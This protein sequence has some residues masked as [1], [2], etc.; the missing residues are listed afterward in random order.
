[1]PLGVSLSVPKN[2]PCP[3]F[4]IA[5]P[6][7]PGETLAAVRSLIHNRTGI[8]D[9]ADIF[10]VV[11]EIYAQL[12]P[13]FSLIF[14]WAQVIKEN[15]AQEHLFPEKLN[16]RCGR[17]CDGVRPEL[18][19]FLKTRE[20]LTVYTHFSSPLDV[21]AAEYYCQSHSCTLNG[22]RVSEIA[23]ST[24]SKSENQ[25]HTDERLRQTQ[26]DTHERI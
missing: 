9:I 15:F 14:Y 1:M 22:C 19:R 11:P 5:A 17:P 8:Y 23:Q 16:E 21:F 7:P 2:L 20:R 24:Y 10:P 26:S 6:L 4:Y 18:Q 12:L 25:R 13:S 3:T